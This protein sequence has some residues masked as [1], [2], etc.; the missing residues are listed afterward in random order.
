VP[1]AIKNGAI[2]LKTGSIA[3]NCKCCGA[4]AE[5]CNCIGANCNLSLQYWSFDGMASVKCDTPGGCYGNLVWLPKLPFGA[6]VR[7]GNVRDTIDA[8][9]PDTDNSI[10]ECGLRLSHVIGDIE[11]HLFAALRCRACCAESFGTQL[12]NTACEIQSP[13]SFRVESGV[14]VKDFTP[15]V[16]P[17]E[18]IH[19]AIFSITCVD[20]PASCPCVEATPTAGFHVAATGP[21]P[22]VQNAPYSWTQ[23]D[24]RDWALNAVYRNC[25][26]SWEITLNGGCYSTWRAWLPAE[27]DCQPPAGVVKWDEALCIP[28]A[29][30]GRVEDCTPLTIT[31]SK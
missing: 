8:L 6:L 16:T 25:L 5:C 20:P 17:G 2:I 10:Y 24:G 13:R 3:E 31:I 1:I 18:I 12:F 23:D 26:C 14:V 22:L 15:A 11:F 28:Y 4:A 27:A 21:R 29:T 30:A 9:S 19:T 7:Y